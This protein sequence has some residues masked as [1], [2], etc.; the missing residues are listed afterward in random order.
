MPAI[1]FSEFDGLPDAL[2]NHRFEVLI[3]PRNQSGAN[4]DLALRCQQ[5][6]VPGSSIEQMIVAIHGYE[7]VFPGRRIYAKTLAATFVETRDGAVHKRIRGWMEDARGSEGGNGVYKSELV[8]V[9]TIRVLD[10]RGDPS[11]EFAVDNLFPQDFQDFQL[12]SQNAAPY[13]PAIVFSF[14]RI[15]YQGIEIK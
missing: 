4:R 5:I 9:G 1:G 8:T 6:S 15:R 2:S 13:L 10:V 11:L 14:D 7:Y 12:D 3:N